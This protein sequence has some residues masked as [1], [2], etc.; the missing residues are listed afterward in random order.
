MQDPLL[1]DPAVFESLMKLSQIFQ[2]AGKESQPRISTQQ[3]S[4]DFEQKFQKFDSERKSKPWTDD[5]H[6]KFI[7]GVETYG[8]SKQ[9]QIAAHVKSRTVMQVISH[10]Q[11]FYQR[12]DKLSN[13]Q[14]DLDLLKQLK[15]H[16]ESQ[17]MQNKALNYLRQTGLLKH[18]A[19]HV[20][21][22][23]SPLTTPVLSTAYVNS[24]QIKQL[25]PQMNHVAAT[26]CSVFK[27]TKRIQFCMSYVAEKL[28]VNEGLCVLVLQSLLQ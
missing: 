11:K 26:F 9:T 25:A 17:A 10:S 27:E 21:I 16:I 20:Q 22:D 7:Q 4:Y 3:N 28:G 15:P 19:D 8:R 12:L 6:R 1:N 5:E 13:Y 23:A 2:N 18:H 14:L 24:A